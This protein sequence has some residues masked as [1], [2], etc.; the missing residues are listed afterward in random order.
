MM[1][2]PAEQTAADRFRQ[3]AER[4]D[5]NAASAFGGAYVIIPPRSA[6]TPWDVL[7]LDTQEDPA[8]FLMVLQAKISAAL[9][10]IRQKEAR[11]GAF[12]GR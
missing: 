9:D 7:V 2:T 11:A 1:D 3:M 4:I 5:H 6:F 12:G 8:Q 10:E